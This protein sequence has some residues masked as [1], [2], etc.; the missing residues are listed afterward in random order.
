[1]VAVPQIVADDAGAVARGREVYIKQSCHSCHGNEGRG[2]GQ[3]VMVDNDGVPTR[4][5]DLTAGIFKGGH[6]AAS[7]YRR[8]SLGMPGTPMPS[9]TNLTPA[10]IVDLAHYIRSLS[11]EEKRNAAILNRERLLARRVAQISEQIDDA[12]WSEAAVTS[13]KTTPIWWRDNSDCDLRVQSLH[14]GTRVAFRLSWKDDTPDQHSARSEAFKDVAAVEL[15]RGAAEPFIGM[16]ADK[17]A[18]DLWVWD[19]DRAKA[20]AAT[21]EQYANTVVD[22][23]PF[24]EAAVESAEFSRPSARLEKQD[25]LALPAKAV[26]NQVV[27]AQRSAAGSSLTAAGPGSATFRL[28]ENQSV[29]SAGQWLDGRWTVVLSRELKTPE[30]GGVA[31]LPGDKLSVAFAIWDGSHR[32]RNGQKLVSIWQD[33][34]L[35]SASDS[36]SQNR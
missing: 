2:D 12:V 20:L 21:E 29:F 15:Y 28:P 31:L 36:D 1:V 22:V 14:D 25:T 23:Y 5:R 30:A 18:V 33:L 7:I 11:D 27:P 3:Q 9:S 8:I 19:A 4:P 13:I 16:G 24:T 35:E 26:G 34:E 32:D 10:Q 17:H 6:D